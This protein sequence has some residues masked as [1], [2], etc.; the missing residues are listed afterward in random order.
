MFQYLPKDNKQLK[1]DFLRRK[2]ALKNKFLGFEDY[3]CWYHSQEKKCAYCEISEVDCQKIVVSGLLK[4]SRF[5][6]NGKTYRGKARGMWLEVDRINPCDKFYHKEN[7]VLACYFCNNDK[8][9]IF[10]FDQ[11]KNFKEN[12]LNFLKSLL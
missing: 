1:N 11:Y 12:R 4:S 9:D 7:C 3:K 10:S 6:Q 5:P 8:S 2:R